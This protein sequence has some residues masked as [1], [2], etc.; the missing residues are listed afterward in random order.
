MFPIKDTPK[1]LDA[2]CSL[3]NKK[4]KTSGAQSLVAAVSPAPS[5]TLPDTGEAPFPDPATMDH[6][7]CPLGLLP[8]WFALDPTLI[9][10]SP[11]WAPSVAPQSLN[12]ALFLEGTWPCSVNQ[13]WMALVMRTFPILM[14]CQKAMLGKLPDLELLAD[15]PPLP[16][17]SR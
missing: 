6:T 12:L 9:L 5:P 4:P 15:W 16:L 8:T 10:T 3:Q 14:L 2:E 7:A 13:L 11:T 1:D 17:S